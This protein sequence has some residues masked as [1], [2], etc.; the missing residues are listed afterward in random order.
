M[1]TY[2]TI[3]EECL[4]ISTVQEPACIWCGQ[5]T[6]RPATLALVSEL[7]EETIADAAQA[8]A[9]HETKMKANYAWEVLWDHFSRDA[10]VEEEVLR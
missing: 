6:L 4:S 2:K 1:E 9:D 8:G 10:F 3:C 5:R 7:F